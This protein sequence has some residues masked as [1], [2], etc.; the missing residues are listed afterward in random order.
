MKKITT[1]ITVLLVLLLLCGCTPTAQPQTP[2]TNNRNPFDFD[3]N[4]VNPEV[5]I[6]G[7]DDD[8]LWQDASV[9]HTSFSSCEVSILRRTTAIYLFFKV[10]DVTPYSFVDQGAADEVTR[11]DSIEFYLDTKLTRVTSPQANCYQINLGRDSRTRILEGG[12]GIWYEWAAMYTFEVR[13]GFGSEEEFYFVE[14]M[15]PLA[16][17]GVSADQDIGIAFGLVDRTVEENKDLA[18]YFT[19]SG[20]NYKSQFIEPQDPSKYL[21]LRASGGDLLL[22]SEYLEAKAQQ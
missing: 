13:E 5:T 12:S 1:I 7:R 4:T 2:T 18:G 17:M 21:V 6:D 16:Q 14:A 19:W 11:S 15:L 22:Y 20:M 10:H 9:T 8:E 3:G